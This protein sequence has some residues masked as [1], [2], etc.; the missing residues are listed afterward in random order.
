MG[1]NKVMY[2]PP[3]TRIPDLMQLV[4]A[5][6]QT[7]ENIYQTERLG[8]VVRFNGHWGRHLER[9][10]RLRFNNRWVSS[11]QEDAITS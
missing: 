11:S 9:Q 8:R 6:F 4:V 3:N 2:L 5:D 1:S 10:Q 7:D